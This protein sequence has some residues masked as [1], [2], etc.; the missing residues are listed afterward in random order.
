MEK[1]QKFTPSITQ[2]VA[3]AAEEAI[4][5]GVAIGSCE[6]CMSI[7]TVYTSTIEDPILKNKC[8]SRI[9]MLCALDDYGHA[10]DEWRELGIVAKRI[11]RA[12]DMHEAK[13]I[14]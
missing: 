3:E 7:L 13:C 14:E 10:L 9:A 2:E 4:L 8:I 11:N 1:V 5:K 12:L 6:E